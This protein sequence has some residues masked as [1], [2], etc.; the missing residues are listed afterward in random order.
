MSAAVYWHYDAA[1]ELLYIGC[2][3]TPLARMMA[4]SYGTDWAQKIVTI[5]LKHFASK[6]LAHEAEVEA[7][8]KERPLYNLNHHPS[9]VG[10]RKRCVSKHNPAPQRA[11]ES[12]ATLGQSRGG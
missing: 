9:P 10:R 6:G 1:G 7:I 8:A 3:I 12:A 2:S 4:H 5:K 11:A